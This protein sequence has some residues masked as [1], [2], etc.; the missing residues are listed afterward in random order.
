[1]HSVTIKSDKPLVV[2]RAEEYESMKETLELLSA[3]PN[4]K[5]ELE[6]EQRS[7]AKGKSITWAEF[8]NKYKV[9]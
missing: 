4:L 1:M 7:I 9:K 6:E 8:K 5:Q 3:N 2:I